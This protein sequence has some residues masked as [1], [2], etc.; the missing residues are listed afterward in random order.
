MTG[1]SKFWKKT[2]SAAVV[3]MLA[4]VVMGTGPVAAQEMCLWNAGGDCWP[5]SAAERAN[6]ATNGWIFNGGAEGTGTM[7]AGGTFSGEGRDQNPPT[8]AATSLG[9]CRWADNNLQG[10]C[11]D[12]FLPQEVADCSGGLNTFWMGACPGTEGTC[13][14]GGTTGNFLPGHSCLVGTT[15]TPIANEAEWNACTGNQIP[16]AQCPAT[17][18]VEFVLDDFEVAGTANRLGGHWYTYNIETATVQ[19]YAQSA[20]GAGFGGTGQAGMMVFSG[21]SATPAHSSAAIGTNL[22]ATDGDPIGADFNGV[23]AI[24]FSARGA[25]GWRIGLR[26]ATTDTP[27]NGEAYAIQ[28]AAQLPTLTGNDWQTFTVP[29]ASLTLPDW[30]ITAGNNYSFVPANATSIDWVIRAEHNAGVAAGTLFIDNVVLVGFTG[31][32]TGTGNFQPGYSCLVGTV[33][34]PIVDEAG[35]NACANRVLSTSTACQGGTTGGDGVF[36]VSDFEVDLHSRFGGNAWWF[37]MD[38]LWRGVP[39]GGDVVLVR[40][41]DGYASAALTQ[42]T[43]TP[44]WPVGAPSVSVFGAAM[45]LNMDF[46]RVIFNDL[47][48]FTGITLDYR[49]TGITGSIAVKLMDT[50]SDANNNGVDFTAVLP[51]SAAWTRDR[52]IPFSSFTLPSWACGPAGDHVGTP[53]CRPFNAANITQIQIVS[54]WNFGETGSTGSA[55]STL[56]IDNVRLTG[57]NGDPNEGLGNGGNDEPT[58]DPAG[59][60]LISRFEMPEPNRNALGGWWYGKVGGWEGPDFAEGDIVYGEIN[61]RYSANTTIAAGQ[62]GL[63]LATDLFSAPE[64]GAAPEFVNASGYAG[65]HFWYRTTGDGAGTSARLELA[66][67]AKH[68]NPALPTQRTLNLPHTFGSWSE[69]R[70]PFDSLAGT[71]EFNRAALSQ[72]SFHVTGTAGGVFAIANVIFHLDVNPIRIPP[73]GGGDV[74]AVI[75]NSCVSLNFADP[76]EI[77]FP[78][79]DFGGTPATLNQLGAYW[80]AN[81][82]D[83]AEAT[84]TTG[85][86]GA[87]AGRHHY[88]AAIP[89]GKEGVLLATNLYPEGTTSY[90]D[91]TTAHTGIY[92]EYRTVGTD[93]EYAR[94][95]LHSAGS[96]LPPHAGLQGG[97]NLPATNGE[98]RAARISITD[99]SISGAG[100]SFMET[101]AIRLIIE[102]AVGSELYIAN[103][104]FISSAT[105]IAEVDR[106]VPEYDYDDMAFVAPVAIRGGEFYAGPSPVAR[107]GSVNLFWS[108]RAVTDGRLL[109]YD[110]SGNVVSRLPVSAGSRG[111]ISS[112][113]LVDSRGRPVATGTYLVRGVLTTSA[114]QERVSVRVTVVE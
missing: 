74:G 108:G 24:R 76:R 42:H 39:E 40:T 21:L 22:T 18:G 56:A 1:I 41:E 57:Y 49:T 71:A 82:T 113:N 37:G 59:N 98:W 52:A 65:I 94:F 4:V 51:V 48:G 20:A 102:G 14:T 87:V 6:C 114:G 3:A 72:I 43:V 95:E 33:C 50:Y 11:W 53:A 31:T 96:A 60:R 62:T 8:T 106:V 77:D 27:N 81:A 45:G 34:T 68:A 46:G 10:S 92:F 12:V 63:I 69:V 38:A 55:G 85:A 19:E 90:F 32:G 54:G 36:L 112:W 67:G 5:L 64:A 30:Y 101:A 103:V 110:A 93:V 47:S 26:V 111:V 58:H 15:C 35:W 23:T 75:C 86:G 2:A 13:P 97:V 100:S 29:I 107:S 78:I 88:T 7:C 16:T 9:C 66:D 91:V 80:F 44:S 25:A 84:G 105:G 89:G 28:T 99:L 104:Y 73:Q 17:G 83:W 61:F 79:S 70:V 109:V